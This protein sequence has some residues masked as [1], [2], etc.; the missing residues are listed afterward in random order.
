MDNSGSSS[1]SARRW[2]SNLL[3]VLAAVLFAY[4]GYTYYQERQGNTGVPP[5]PQSIAGQAQLKNVR[6]ALAAQ[7]LDVQYGRQTVRIEGVSPVGQE[8]TA[9]GTPV[10]IFLFESPA[11]RSEQTSGLSADS[12]E[13]KTPSGADAATGELVIVSGSNV[14]AVSDGAPEDVQQKIEAGVQSLP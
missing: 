6:D 1:F 13:I 4:V 2:I 10:Y 8:L 3:F 9:D 11:A 7:G 12:L 5:T 14:L